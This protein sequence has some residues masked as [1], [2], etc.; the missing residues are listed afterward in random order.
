MKNNINISGL[1]EFVNEVKEYPEQASIKYGV[2]LDWLSG[3]RTRAT[4]QNIN[5]G[6]Q[7]HVR[8]FSFEI[9]E[10]TQLL[11]L[12]RF[13]TPQEYL[14]AGVA[15]CMSVTFLAGATMLGIT[16]ENLRIEINGEI[17]LSCFLGLET[18]EPAGFR[19]L[20]CNIIVSGNG[21]SEQYELLRQRVIK[22]SPNYA[23][24]TQ[25]VRMIPVVTIEN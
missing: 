8:N 16:L 10:P 21:T 13:P 9:D 3:T 6:G 24:I 1:S 19:E 7:Q 5:L 23:S 18:R 11:G 4:V 2:Q 22:H 14:M 20:T 17:D 25:G 15:G 12:N